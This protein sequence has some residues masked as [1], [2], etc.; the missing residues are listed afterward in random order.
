MAKEFICCPGQITAQTDKG[1]VRGYKYEGINIFKGLPYA[2]ALRF[3]APEEADTWEGEKSCTDFGPVCPL[4]YE[5]RPNGELGVPHRYWYQDEDCLNLN[6]W[7]PGLD[8][9]KRPVMV[10]LH[11]G[12]FEA[13]SAIEQTA[14]DGD[15]MAKYGDVVVVGINHRLNILGY[16]DL[17]AFGPEYA[18]SAN[19]GM[20]DIIA[21]L[22]WVNKNIAAFG[23]D[24]DNVTLFG[25]SG[26]GMKITTLLQMPAADG[27]FHKGI[28]MSGV[29]G[30]ALGSA[31]PLDTEAI[32]KGMMEELGLSDIHELETVPYHDLIAAYNKA[33]PAKGMMMGFGPKKNDF[34]AGDPVNDGAGF[35]PET[36]GIPLM[37]GSVYSEFLSF[38]GGQDTRA[39][40]KEAGEA[41]VK[42]MLGEAAD[43]ILPLYEAAFPERNPLDMLKLDFIFRSAELPYMAMRSALNDCT[44]SYLF[45]QD[46]HLDGIKQPWHCCD[47]PYIFHNCDITPMTQQE[48]VDKLEAEIFGAAIAFARTGDPNCD[49]I[50]NWPC[51]KPDAEYTMFYQNEPVVRKNHD[52]ELM[53]VYMKVMGPMFAKMMAGAA[54]NIQH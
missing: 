32:A 22:K 28:V 10:W 29:L 17:S 40:T 39:M 3:H 35:R 27:L 38:G 52:H 23:G 13:G 11:G 41:A 7:T 49:A 5:T 24:P 20:D 6:I 2:K 12:G 16:F 45:N 36:A 15:Q 44:W 43:Q 51:S 33:N 31:Q 34:Y 4:A 47:I 48:G 37:V 42:G 30:G 18:N 14:Y 1:I 53:P 46:F 25:Q 26:G 9:K 50:P 8:D 21:A 19:A 54:D